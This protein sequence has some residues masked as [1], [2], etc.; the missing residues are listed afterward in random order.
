MYGI[1]FE[2]EVKVTV[3]TNLRVILPLEQL[4]FMLQD[5]MQMENQ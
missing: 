4:Q 3:I 2:V 5:V 1:T